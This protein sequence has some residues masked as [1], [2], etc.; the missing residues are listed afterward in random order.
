MVNLQLGR[1]ELEQ[2]LSWY[3]SAERAGECDT[4]DYALYEKLKI[5][6][7][8]Y[9]CRRKD[10]EEKKRDARQKEWNEQFD[11]H[12]ECPVCGTACEMLFMEGR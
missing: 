9:S 10:E 7:H 8:E 12:T 4:L 1:K 2:V 6:Y 3:E 5:Q 11:D